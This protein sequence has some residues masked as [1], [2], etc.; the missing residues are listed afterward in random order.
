MAMHLE[1]EDSK[2][3]FQKIRDRVPIRRLRTSSTTLFP[4]IQVKQFN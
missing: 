1:H 2:G 3:Y 4:A